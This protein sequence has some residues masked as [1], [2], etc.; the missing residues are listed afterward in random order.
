MNIQADATPQH[1][2]VQSGTLSQASASSTC[3]RAHADRHRQP[4]AH[5]LGAGL[6]GRQSVAAA[7]AASAGPAAA[8][9]LALAV[10]C[11]APLHVAPR[12]VRS[13]QPLCITN[14]SQLQAGCFVL[15]RI[16][17]DDKA[18]LRFYELALQPDSISLL[19]ELKAMTLV[20]EATSGVQEY[21]VVWETRPKQSSGSSGC[22]HTLQQV[23][24][25]QVSSASLHRKDS[26]DWNL[27]TGC[28][29]FRVSQSALCSRLCSSRVSSASSHRKDSNARCCSDVT[30][31][32]APLPSAATAPSTL[33]PTMPGSLAAAPGKEHDAQQ[34]AHRLHGYERAAATAPST[35]S[36]VMPGSLAAV[37]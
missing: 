33:S 15:V 37:R 36:P 1:T 23:V 22:L 7:L 6:A 2:A 24:Q 3:Q 10:L 28:Y 29:H 19:Q 4:Q 27:T 34:D 9:L 20:H 25:Q 14:F 21:R 12:A 13:L 31:A 35:I 18:V 5:L 26:S 32:M 11:L 30:S 17:R 8:A 16:S